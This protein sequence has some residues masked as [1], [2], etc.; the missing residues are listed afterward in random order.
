MKISFDKLEKSHIK[1]NKTDGFYAI[2]ASINI[3]GKIFCFT[4]ASSRMTRGNISRALT[5]QGGIFTNTVNRNVDY[6]VVGDKGNSNWA[7]SSYGLKIQRAITLQE[8]KCKILIIHEEDFW[9]ALNNS[10]SITFTIDTSI[11]ND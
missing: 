5:L 2:D 11:K 10:K 7:F 4:G 6:L 9:K 8:S 1:E 3:K